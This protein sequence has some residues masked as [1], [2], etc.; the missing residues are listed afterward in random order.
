M[1]SNLQERTVADVLGA[2]LDSAGG[3]VFVV[4]PDA[5]TLEGLI[6]ALDSES[7][8][9]S[10]L[11]DSAALKDVLDD[12]L[13]ASRAATHVESGGLDIRRYDRGTNAVIVTDDAVVAVVRGA[14][15]VAGLVTDD[16]DF[17]ADANARFSSAW[18]NAE[19][20]TLRTPSIDR[21][22]ETLEAE[23]GEATADDFD[24]VLSSLDAARGDGEGID[25]VT[26]SLLVAAKNEDLLYDVS[27]WGEDV[28]I[29]SK[30]TFSR[31]KTR[32]EE[33]GLIDTEKVP[34]DVG[35]PRLRLRLADDRLRE[36]DVDRLADVAAS[37]L[38][39]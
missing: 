16:G 26:A 13:V 36:A 39:A 33:Q 11:A 9:V 3:G 18:E 1:N 21:V 8:P 25:E 19:P 34:I 24:A 37:M 23:L 7:P 10:L 28:G 2:V 17:V 38:S 15:R 32:M 22:R 31:T 6:E 12:F 29:A 14:D 4:A 20:Y 27:R 35:R 5:E 30:A